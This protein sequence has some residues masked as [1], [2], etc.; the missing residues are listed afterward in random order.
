MTRLTL[1]RHGQTDWNL[2]RRLQGSSDIPLN[3]TGRAQAAAAREGLWAGLRG[4]PT[5]VASSLGRAIE[6]ARILCE[7]HGVEVHADARIAERSYGV[8]EGL[9][10]DQRAIDFPEEFAR[11]QTGREPRIAG[12]ETHAALAAR[13]REAALE[14]ADRVGD[15]GELVF[16]SHG[17]AG[18]MLL[19]ELLGL[20]L[21]G[22]A[23]GHLENASW[24]RLALG[25]D[26][27]WTLER[28]N[29]G[30]GPVPLGPAGALL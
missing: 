1:V 6:T 20:P 18:R 10:A 2:A 11:W 5:V 17:S 4:E 13:V 19:L 15:G 27:R 25:G 21:T 23:L 8:W 16:V 26:G 14:W 7:G 24:S 12:Y 28:H 29:V 22:R 30:A 9:E 3:D